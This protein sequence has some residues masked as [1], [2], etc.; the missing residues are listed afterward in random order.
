MQPQASA[1]ASRAAA[2]LQRMDF[3]STASLFCSAISLL[4]NSQFDTRLVHQSWTR[5]QNRD[6][7]QLCTCSCCESTGTCS[8][9]NPHVQSKIV[10]DTLQCYLAT[11]S[12]Q[13]LLDTVLHEH[14]LDEWQKLMRRY[15][16]QGSV[17]P[18]AQFGLLRED[19]AVTLRY[20]EVGWLY[21]LYS[22]CTYVVYTFSSAC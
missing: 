3:C 16:K 17:P 21:T 20:V 22:L 7:E 1:A 14:I 9:P 12:V 5:S 2:R 18:A 11:P 8:R 10:P 6:D 13:Y 19:C 15:R 4:T